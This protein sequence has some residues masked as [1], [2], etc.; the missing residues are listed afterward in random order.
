[1][2]SC[3]RVRPLPERWIMEGSSRYSDHVHNH[4]SRQEKLSE[5][6]PDGREESNRTQHPLSRLGFQRYTQ[7]RSYLS[8]GAILF[9][10]YPDCV[11]YANLTSPQGRR[12]NN[13]RAKEK[14]SQMSDVITPRK[15]DA[16]H[17]D[18]IKAAPLLPDELPLPVE[19]VHLTQEEQQCMEKS[20]VRRLDLSVMPVV[21][22]LFLLNI[23]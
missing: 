11:V 15:H 20:L 17:V 4:I 12:R 10:K 23:L 5:S 22:L 1:M 9:W 6:L 2:C 19:I 8:S 16:E 3:V 13:Y 21:F 7:H 14:I 18:D